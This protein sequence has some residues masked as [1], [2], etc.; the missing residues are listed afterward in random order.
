MNNNIQV[1]V[2]VEGKTEIFFIKKLQTA[3]SKRLEKLNTSFK[4]TTTGIKIAEIVG[5]PR[6]RKSCPLFNE[7]VSAIENLK[8]CV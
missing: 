1:M 2:I 6:M 5:I 8:Y 4:K 7:W 3:P